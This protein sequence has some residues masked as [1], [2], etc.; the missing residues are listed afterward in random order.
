M[1]PTFGGQELLESL[2][3]ASSTSKSRKSNDGSRGSKGSSRGSSN[4]TLTS[5]HT[6]PVEDAYRRIGQGLSQRAQGVGDTD[7]HNSQNHRQRQPSSRTARLGTHPSASFTKYQRPA[8]KPFNPHEAAASAMNPL[9]G[10]PTPKVAKLGGS[11]HDHGSSGASTGGGSA[12]TASGKPNQ[13]LLKRITLQAKETFHKWKRQQKAGYVNKYAPSAGSLPGTLSTSNSSHSGHTSATSY[14]TTAG[15]SS[16]GRLTEQQL[17]LQQQQQQAMSMPHDGTSPQRYAA[18]QMQLQQQQQHQQQ[19]ISTG[20]PQGPNPQGPPPKG[21]LSAVLEGGSESTFES[22][23][24]HS[25]PTITS[26]QTGMS[27]AGSVRTSNSQKSAYHQYPGPGSLPGNGGGTSM[28]SSSLRGGSA[29]GGGIGASV[30]NNE[31]SLHFA[32]PRGRCLTQ[33]SDPVGSEGLD[34]VEGN[35]ILCQND[36]LIVPSRSH[37]RGP[38]VGSNQNII[39]SKGLEFH[40]QSLLGQGTFAQ[41]FCCWESVSKKHVALKII[42][43]KP[44]F[45]KQAAVEIEVFRALAAKTTDPNNSDNNTNPDDPASGVGGS[46]PSSPH[47]VSLLSSF[48]YKSHLCLVF[49]KLGLNLYEVLKRRQFR[50]LPLPMVRS[51]ARQGIEGV[52]ELAGKTIVHCDLKPENILLVGDDVEKDVVGAGESKHN[53]NDGGPPTTAS[54]DASVVSASSNTS[55]K[56]ALLG[57]ANSPMPQTIKLIDFGSACF[58]GYSA[59]TYI[60]S[61]FYRSPEVLMGLPYDSA[62]DMWSL[63]CVAAEL[64]LGLPILPGVHEHDQCGRIIEMIGEI[65]DWM[66]EQGSKATK[67]YLKYVPRSAN[68]SQG[69]GSTGSDRAV[70]ESTNGRPMLPQWRLKSQEEYIKSLT[71]NEIRKKGGLAKLEKQPANRYFKRTKLSDIIMLHGQHCVGDEKELLGMFVHFLYGLL[72]PDPWKRWTAY[73]ASQ[74][75]FITGQT[76]QLRKKGPETKLDY[77]EENQA[78]KHFD[79]YWVPPWDPGICRRKLL[80]VQRMREKQ[81]D[82]RRGYAQQQGSDRSNQQSPSMNSVNSRAQPMMVADSPSVGHMSVDG[83]KSS[84]PSQIASKQQLQTQYGR[85]GGRKQPQ[86]ALASSMSALGSAGLQAQMAQEPVQHEHL[87]KTPSQTGVQPRFAGPQSFT[88]HGNYEEGPT[89]ADFMYALQRPGNVPGLG[90]DDATVAS[91][92]SISGASLGSSHMSVNSNQHHHQQRHHYSQQQ[93]QYGHG[94]MNQNSLPRYQQTEATNVSSLPNAAAYPN[95][96]AGMIGAGGVSFQGYGNSS[97]NNFD[98][99]QGGVQYLAQQQ[100]LQKEQQQQR[101][102]GGSQQQQQP[103]SMD[104]GQPQLTQYQHE[105]LILEQQKQLAALQQQHQQQLAALQQQ[106]QM[107]FQQQQQQF[108]T[109]Y[110]QTG[111]GYYY[112]TSADGT[113]VLMQGGGGGG[114]PMGASYDGSAASGAYMMPPQQ[115][116]GSMRDR[117]AGGRRPSGHGHGQRSYGR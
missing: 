85:G 14:T 65:P 5:A 68:S 26:Q 48:M 71:Q 3:Q 114:Q 117:N 13:K 39:S 56:S 66:L 34:N 38:N 95:Q 36:I 102:R 8:K 112:V 69:S 98:Q 103:Q 113:P 88:A 79:V 105:M 72:D 61:R 96:S 21:L 22:E 106:Q 16:Y 19:Q 44:A 17:L 100:R 104:Q 4:S 41:V 77:K 7:Y 89:D 53:K 97:L 59:H 107:A 80:N 15:G 76:G 90:R 116:G 40:V 54:S 25:L 18:M 82:R 2:S 57:G 99:G 62:I 23:S 37:T 81:N 27:K 74:H 1:D 51:L 108:M 55:K 46:T 33:P 67:Y 73:Q 45:T 20:A 35:L 64:F 43:N 42:K 83:G 29:H 6:N 31:P 111:N 93:Q 28:L 91:Q 70:A 109:Q 32:T 10:P 52:K 92:A 30:V 60:Q 58:E 24:V 78:N 12:T 101:A 115:G 47:M 94:R 86:G 84:P 87:M 9:H 49:E 75:P 63:G 50:G 11:F 110:G